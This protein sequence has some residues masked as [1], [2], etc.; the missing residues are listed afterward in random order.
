MKTRPMS[1]MALTAIMPRLSSRA[2]EIRLHSEGVK[3]QGA[4]ASFPAPLYQK[5]FKSY[6][7]SHDGV[8]I[9]YQSIGSGGGVKSVID[10]TVDFGASDAAMSAGDMAKVD[11][12]VQLLPMTAGCIVL[13]YNLKGVTGL[14]LSRAAYAGIFLGKVKKWNDPLIAKNN[15]GLALPDQPINVVVRADG[16]GTTFVF[17]K[18]LS[19]ISPEFAKNPGVNKLPNW[20]TGTRS[21]GNEGVTASIM[22]TPGAIGY[23]E[24]GYAKSQNLPMAHSGKQVGQLR[25]GLDRRQRR[26][27]WRRR[28]SRQPDCLGS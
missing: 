7:A 10:K 2:V 11:G 23:I 21:K 6:S 12:G 24:Y 27:P 9:D 16:S 13:T 17:T 26:R 25:R 22:M 8:Q 3:L 20:P 28:N 15:A 5:W 18:H 4:G 14:K 1:L 19:A